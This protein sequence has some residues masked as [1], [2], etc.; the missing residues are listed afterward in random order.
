MRKPA[1]SRKPAGSLGGVVNGVRYGTYTALWSILG[2]N[3]EQAE[4]G[5]TSTLALSGQRFPAGR[6]RP[7]RYSGKLSQSAAQ[8][9][10]AA[11]GGEVAQNYERGF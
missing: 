4:S 5:C 2:L 11:T 9:L 7:R 6:I 10:N 1:R 8:R 3:L